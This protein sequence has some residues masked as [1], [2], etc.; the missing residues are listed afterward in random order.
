[1]RKLSEYF[2]SDRRSFQ[3]PGSALRVFINVCG[4]TDIG[5]NHKQ[6]LCQCET[7]DSCEPAKLSM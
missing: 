1:M 7:F 3:A 6:S 2:V 5:K 4:C